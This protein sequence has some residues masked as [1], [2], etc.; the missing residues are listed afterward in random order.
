MGGGGGVQGQQ[1]LS[2]AESCSAEQNQRKKS[3]ATGREPA[4]EN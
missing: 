4:L 2:Q 3:V 1:Q